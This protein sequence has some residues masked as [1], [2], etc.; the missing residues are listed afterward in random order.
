MQSKTR[1]AP[2]RSRALLWAGGATILLVALSD[3]LLFDVDAGISVFLVALATALAI[4]IL[5]WRRQRFRWGV[6]GF[7]AALILSL[8]LIE[9]ASLL[10][11]M[12]SALGLGLAALM[13]VRLVPH[14]LERMPE[15]LLR[16]LLPAPIRLL[17]DAAALRPAV[18]HQA[19]RKAALWLVAWIVPLGLGAVFA[20]LF[21][22]ANPLIE[23]TLSALQPQ[24][25]FD[26]LDP[27]RLMLWL[28][29]AMGVWALLRP[30]LLRRRRRRL[31][32]QV[33]APRD[34]SWFGS[35]A[36]LRSLLVFNALFAVQTALD[37]TYLWGGI[38]LPDGMGHAEYAHRGAYPLIVTAL[39]AGAFVLVAM[40]ERSP[41]RDNR[42][43]RALVYLFIAQNV[44]L[45][46][47][48]MLRL[49]LY[50][51]VY[52]LT[53]MRLAAG[54]WMGL[55]AIGLVLILARIW[56]RQSNG[57]LVATNLLALT[58]VLYASAM[59]DLSAHIA[60]FN[61]EHSRELTGADR[62]VDLHYLW[63]LGPSAIP[64]FDRLIPRLVPG[65]ALWD[66]ARA[67][68]ADLVRTLLDGPQDWRNWSWR[69]QRLKDYLV[70][71]AVASAPPTRHNG[72]VV[73]R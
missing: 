16:L 30:K 45:C 40:R 70:M 68:R 33:V 23:T 63:D 19:G 25:L 43:I 71:H 31:P 65:T 13:A 10:S 17:R 50:V 39:L 3:L 51:E 57:W 42:V 44:L 53:E 14:R 38:A 73:V 9:A 35:A 11:V 32:E 2:K 54:I 6:M 52:S 46:L 7:I 24:V 66:D 37:L 49:E 47:S 64:A 1:T 29:V 62:S 27:F 69:E 61:V 59:L 26:L 56:L 36:I 22:A 4:L 48:A 67:I 58:A 12:L 18:Q 15:I 20:Y 55:V 41:A 28:I 5:A 34:S 21:A 8:P 72:M 60:R